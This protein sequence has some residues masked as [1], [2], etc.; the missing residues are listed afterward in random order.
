MNSFRQSTVGTFALVLAFTLLFTACK[1]EEEPDLSE[2]EL[3]C[4]VDGS[5]WEATLDVQASLGSQDLVAISGSD[6][7]AHQI[8]L[9]ILGVT[10][11]GTFDV[12]GSLTNQ[13]TGRWT[14]GIGQDDTYTTSVGQGVGTVEI[15]KFDADVVEGTFSFTCANG[16]QVEKSITSGSFSAPING[17]TTERNTP[18][19]KRN[20][21]APSLRPFFYEA[22]LDSNTKLNL[23][24]WITL[25]FG[26]F[27]VRKK[28]RKMKT[29]I[30]LSI[31]MGLIIGMLGTSSCCKPE[32]STHLQIIFEDY[33]FEALDSVRV[34]KPDLYDDTEPSDT[35]YH[36]IRG[37]GFV[38]IPVY[39][40]NVH[41]PDYTIECD[42]PAFHYQ[43]TE[44]E[45]FYRTAEGASCEELWFSYNW[46]GDAREI[47]KSHRETVTPDP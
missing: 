40:D 35:V 15:T 25:D 46:N 31:G 38:N 24:N 36:D 13:N 37:S 3:T 21:P 42:S 1:K 7:S 17:L 39:F 26:Y 4:K 11:T 9:N 5:D 19:F 43:I 23:S 44:L 18:P 28:G 8:S 2:G 41:N 29:P 6:A 16:S 33:D 22:N 27:A 47:A 32:E 10:G 12:G 20:G 14:E 34:I 30:L 45:A